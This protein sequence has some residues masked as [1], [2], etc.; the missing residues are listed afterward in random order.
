VG[1]GEGVGVGPGVGGVAPGVG[2]G[3]DGNEIDY[4]RIFMAR[5]VTRKAQVLAK[6]EPSYTES[7]RKFSV[8]GTVR[9]RVILSSVGKV[10]GVA[11]VTRLPHGLTREAVEAARAVKFKPAE[12]DGRIV[13]QYIIIEYNFNIY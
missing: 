6:P 12:K 11:V 10:S 4:T 3:S 5:E 1:V 9:V 7:A 13:S 2:S 8:T